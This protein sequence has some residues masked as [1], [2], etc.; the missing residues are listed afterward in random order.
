M[1]VTGALADWLNVDAVAFQASLQADRLAEIDSG[2]ESLNSGQFK[3]V[4]TRSDREFAAGRIPKSVHL[5]WT[6]LLAE[7]GRF[8]TPAKLKE[9]FAK[10]GIAPTET[11]VCY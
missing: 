4:D 3:V 7:D 5:E 6:Q 11:A 8:K 9:L 2:K 10:S 1:S